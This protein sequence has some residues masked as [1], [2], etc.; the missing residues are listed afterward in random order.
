MIN[1]TISSI[2]SKDG[3]TR[4]AIDCVEEVPGQAKIMHSMK[5]LCEEEQDKAGTFFLF[6]SPEKLI[7][8]FTRSKNKTRNWGRYS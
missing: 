3:C 5:N 1:T 6:S 2:M 4:A 7:E 8:L